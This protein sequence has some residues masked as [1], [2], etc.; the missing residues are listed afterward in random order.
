MHFGKK[1]RTFWEKNKVYTW[2]GIQPRCYNHIT[3]ELC[4][5]VTYGQLQKMQY[6]Q[7]SKKDFEKK[8][9]SMVTLGTSKFY[10]KSLFL[11]V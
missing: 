11:K 5:M 1:K 10:K 8:F 3:L 7:W 6:I 2:I 9:S 4:K